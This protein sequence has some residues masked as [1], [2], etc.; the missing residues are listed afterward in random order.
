MMQFGFIASD[1][2][3]PDFSSFCLCMNR[4]SASLKK[5]GK[6]L[7]RDAVN[8]EIEVCKQAKLSDKI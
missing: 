3:L 5:P 1:G 8:E 7:I 6:V 4:N 2:L